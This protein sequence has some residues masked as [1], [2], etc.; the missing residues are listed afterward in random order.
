MHYIFYK[1]GY[2]YH[3]FAIDHLKAQDEIEERY[4]ISLKDAPWEGVYGAKVLEK[5]QKRPDAKER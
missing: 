5:S 2:R 3:T 4:H 1:D